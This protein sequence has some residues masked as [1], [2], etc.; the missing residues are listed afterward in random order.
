MRERIILLHVIDSLALLQYP[1]V[2]VFETLD[3]ILEVL[4]FLKISRGHNQNSSNVRHFVVLLSPILLLLL[5]LTGQL[6]ANLAS[7]ALFI[8]S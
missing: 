3:S 4:M 1:G 8:L 6:V 7:T 2:D 5:L